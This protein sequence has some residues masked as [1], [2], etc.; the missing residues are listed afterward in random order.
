MK[1][2]SDRFVAGKVLAKKLQGYLKEPDT[3]VLALPRGGVPVAYEIAKR[4]SL[5]LDVFIVRKLGVPG[6]E[7]LAMGAIASG[8]KVIFNKEIK[9]NLQLSEEVINEVIQKETLELKR[10]EAIYRHNKPSLQLKNKKIILVDDGIATGASVRV[11]INVLRQA[12]PH[13][14]IIAV[15]VIAMDTYKELVTKAHHFIA[16]LKPIHFYAVGL[17]YDDFNPIRDEEVARL[18]DDSVAYYS[19]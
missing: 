14:I 10:R 3:I 5:P 13:E 15:P 17:W 9:T 7:E 4:L 12:A 11:A 19:K 2:F 16:L 1:K 18:L 8:G 6:Q